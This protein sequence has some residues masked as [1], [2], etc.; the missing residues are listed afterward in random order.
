MNASDEI[1]NSIRLLKTPLFFVGSDKNAGKTTAMM[2]ISSLLKGVN[3]AFLTTGRDGEEK[4]VI[5]GN[6]KP[7]VFVNRNDLFATTEN[8]LFLTD[9]SLLSSMGIKTSG[10]Q[11]RIGIWKAL[12]RGKIELRGAATAHEIWQIISEM[13]KFHKGLIFIDGAMDRWAAL[14]NFPSSFIL[15]LGGASINSVNEGIL[16][17][18]TKLNLLNLPLKKSDENFPR[19]TMSDLGKVTQ[20]Q[21]KVWFDGALTKFVFSELQG[22]G[23][24]KVVVNSPMHIFLPPSKVTKQHLSLLTKPQLVGV[25]SNPWSPLAKSVNSLELVDA[26]RKAFPKIPITDILAI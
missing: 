12:G 17:L 8:A 26:L 19:V 5:F 18:K 2:K 9:T 24:E 11:E 13:Q 25:I 3:I 20:L 10:N 21:K 6:S 15:V 23:V 4:D 1:L 7:F 16:W 22:L 14:S